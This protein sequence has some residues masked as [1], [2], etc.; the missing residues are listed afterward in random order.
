MFLREESEKITHWVKAVFRG[1]SSC[2][3]GDSVPRSESGRESF[4]VTAVCELFFPCETGFL[5]S[6]AGLFLSFIFS[7]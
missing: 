6:Q 7:V 2:Y 4:G 3:F 5:G 1:Q